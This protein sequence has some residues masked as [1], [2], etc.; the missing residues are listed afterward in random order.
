MDLRRDILMPRRAPWNP[1]FIT[2]SMDI[3]IG[4][5]TFIKNFWKVN[6]RFRERKNSKN[7]FSHLVD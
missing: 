4:E 6:T 7:L 5:N 1:E 3:A 2:G